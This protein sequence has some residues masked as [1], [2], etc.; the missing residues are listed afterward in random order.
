VNNPTG[1]AAVVLD[2][3]LA[4]CPGRVSRAGLREETQLGDDGLGLDSIEIVEVLLGCEDH[5]GISVHTLF[6]GAPLTF[7]RVV[8]HFAAS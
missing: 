8:S 5:Y 1:V 2:I 7:G 6:D 3:L 4:T